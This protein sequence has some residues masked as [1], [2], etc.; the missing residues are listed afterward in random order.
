MAR[1]DNEIKFNG[2]LFWAKNDDWGQ[3]SCTAD[4]KVLFTEESA[5]K[6]KE[7]QLEPV[8]FHFEAYIYGPDTME[9]VAKLYQS[10]AKQQSGI[11]EHPDIGKVRV[12]FADGGFRFKRTEKKYNYRELSLYF[13]VVKTAALNIQVVDVKELK[14]EQLKTTATTAEQGFLETFNE[15]FTLDGFP[16][17]VKLQ[18]FDNLTKISAKLSK[19]T[20]NN[21][22]SAVLDPV[23]G[24]WEILTAAI[25]GIGSFFQSYLNFEGNAKNKYRAYM[26]MAAFKP[27]LSASD[28]SGHEQ[29]AANT[30][31]VV[32]L[33]QQ[34]A[35]IKAAEMVNDT[36]TFDTK[37]E[38]E[39]A[40]DDFL[41][42]SEKVALATD[43]KTA[44][45]YVL[46][47]ANQAIEVLKTLQV[48]KVRTIVK[49]VSLPAAVIC[50]EEN[51][52]E[53]TFI[54]NNKI[55]HPLFVNAGVLLEISDA[56]D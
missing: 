30:D 25:G 17:L 45:N 35:L 26:D 56:G 15:K 3:K 23:V 19:L 53:E 12:K 4:K 29:I 49:P 16:N 5:E 31:A 13:K 55:R 28:T 22:I 11:L 32:S 52:D 6:S 20:A 48:A 37:N 34:T 1:K 46:T 40:V 14:P 33:I 36:E 42:V 51:C 2:I 43:D 7:V 38:V 27:D 9:K 50:W 44:Q 24:S 18:T 10:F 21:L 8:D 47:V 39:E 54:K 41:Q